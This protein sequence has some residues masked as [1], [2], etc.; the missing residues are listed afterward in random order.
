VAAVSDLTVF[1]LARITDDEA[2]ARKL[3]AMEG[4][5]M[6]GPYLYNDGLVIGVGRVLAEC[7]AKRRIIELC[8]DYDSPTIIWE[9]DRILKVLALPYTE[10]DQ[11]RAEWR[12]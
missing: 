4:D 9:F 2:P 11:Y 3:A 12:P 7:D 10:H 5:D 8:L 1:L 6:N